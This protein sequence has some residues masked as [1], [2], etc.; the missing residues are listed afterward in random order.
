MT[1]VLHSKKEFKTCEL[2]NHVFDR[3]GS[4]FYDFNEQIFTKEL[5]WQKLVE[6]YQILTK[7]WHCVPI[8]W[9]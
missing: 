6:I 4:Q 3:R 1:E 9:H 5:L 8:N 2:V 7:L